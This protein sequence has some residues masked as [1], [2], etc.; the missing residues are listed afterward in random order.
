M[1]NVIINKI[2]DHTLV[3]CLNLTHLLQHVMF[4]SAC[5]CG[6]CMFWKIETSERETGREGGYVCMSTCACET[7]FQAIWLLERKG[8]EEG[9]CWRAG[10]LRGE[11]RANESTGATGEWKSFCYFCGLLRHK[12]QGLICLKVWEQP[13]ANSSSTPPPPFRCL[14]T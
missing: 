12:R 13:S 2:S 7:L 3:H 10:H 9:W 5:R 1:P 4:L 6:Y 11:K 14:F 8:M